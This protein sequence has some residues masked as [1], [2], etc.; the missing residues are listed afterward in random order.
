M[1]DTIAGNWWRREGVSGAGLKFD[2]YTT[3]IGLSAG[4]YTP[5]APEIPPRILPSGPAG[6]GKFGAYCGAWR[7]TGCRICV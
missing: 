3:R 5:G 6:P 4:A 1:N 2:D 7:A